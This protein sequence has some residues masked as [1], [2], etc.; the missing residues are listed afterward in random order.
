MLYKY[1]AYKPD[2]SIVDGT[3][4]AESDKMA[5]EA[6]YGAGFKYVLKI[7]ARGERK[8]W[9]QYVPTFFGIKP[10]E[11]IDFSRQLAAFIESG[12]SLHTALELL[13]DQASG[14]AMRDMLSGII[15][16]LEKGISLSEALKAYPTVFNYSYL[17]VVQSTERAGDIG[18]GLR[19]IADYMEKRLIISARI[20]KALSYPI[21]V[22]VLGIAVMVLLVA[23]V[24]PPILEL[25]KSFE[26]ELPTLTVFAIALLNFVLNYKLQILFVVIL[27]AA[28][29]WLLSRLP[30]GRLFYD[31][32]ALRSPIF[33]N[34]M[35]EHNMGHFCRTASILLKAGLPLPTIMEISIKTLSQNRIIV[36]S[37]VTVKNKLMQGEGLARPMAADPLFPKM[38]VRMVTVGE[39]TGTLEASLVTLADYYEDHT[40]KKIQSLIGMIEPTLTLA[41]GIGIAFVMLSMITPI[42][43]ILNNVK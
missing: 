2:N 28:L 3:I 20:K 10:Q 32:M 36:Q 8:T 18:Q 34:I 17:Q 38:M 11:I 27:L 22:I 12:S 19:E 33:G 5:E 7:Q 21:F 23:V 35:I 9:R 13:K 26:A 39:Q 16:S 6:L 24:L 15:A 30:W 31:R 1:S 29:G 41:M 25:F 14:S 42:Y 43:A 37:F 4:E 40:N